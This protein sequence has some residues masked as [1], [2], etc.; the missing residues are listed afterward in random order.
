MRRGARAVLRYEP[1][2]A[3]AAR[4]QSLLVWVVCSGAQ[5]IGPPLST[6]G[7]CRLSVGIGRKTPF[8]DGQHSEL[9]RRG[10]FGS[11]M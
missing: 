9:A 7:R 2:K 1:H 10:V 5:R 3:L 6:N 8:C 11:Q 4:D